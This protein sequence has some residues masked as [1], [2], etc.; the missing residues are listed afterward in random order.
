MK[1]GESNL[2]IFVN[3]LVQKSGKILT[4]EDILELWLLSGWSRGRIAYAVQQAKNQGYLTPLLRDIF[5]VWT[6]PDR[7]D[8]LYWKL[9]TVL[10]RRDAPAGAII[11]GEKSMEYHLRN[12]SLPDTLILYTYS[13][14]KRVRL[15]DG[16]E[17]HFRTLKSGEKKGGKN[18]Y[19]LLDDYTIRGTIDGS[20]FNILNLEA[21][22]LDAASLR[23][24][25][26]WFAEDLFEKFLRQYEKKLSRESLWKLVSY[27]YIRAVNRLRAF[28]KERGFIGL[29]EV[30]LDVIK[31]E[32]W[33]CYLKL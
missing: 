1:I 17:V 12:F 31:R 22:L 10:I 3:K 4:R 28:T 27:R 21:S 5:S 33:G 19:R 13:T 18:M 11:S 15:S 14:N 30:L 25:E 23:I 26:V 20:E 7:I 29:Y 24:H 2:H 16:R 6:P 8:D 9:I 32:G